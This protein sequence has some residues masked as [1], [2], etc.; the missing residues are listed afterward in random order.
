VEAILRRIIQ[1][2]TSDLTNNKEYI[3]PEIA[4]ALITT[5]EELDVRSAFKELKLHLQRMSKKQ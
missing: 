2:Q 3:T 5:L 1:I 4:D